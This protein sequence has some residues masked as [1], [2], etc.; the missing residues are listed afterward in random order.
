MSANPNITDV[1]RQALGLRIRSTNHTPIPA[2]T[3]MPEMDILSVT[4]RTVRARLHGET[5]EHRRKPTGCTG[6][7]IWTFAGENPPEE[8]SEWVFWSQ[9]TKTTFEIE[10]PVSV[11][12]GSKVWLAAGWVNAKG[13]IGPVCDPVS[14]FTQFGG[15][16]LTVTSAKKKAA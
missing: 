9:T 2:P 12:A 7:Y 15:L 11:E 13:Q 10:F 4:G 14:T 1:Q 8:L 3:E 16:T 6:A 5:I